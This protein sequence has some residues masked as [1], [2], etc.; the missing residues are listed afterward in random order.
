MNGSTDWLSAAAIVS[1][2]IIVGL[3]L[4]Y[5]A[6]RKRGTLRAETAFRDL[7]ARRDELVDE[8]RQGDLSVEARTS[9]EI[10]TANVLREIDQ[11]SKA[12]HPAEAELPAPNPFRRGLL[13]G[14]AS[15]AGTVLILA[16][17]GIFVIESAKTSEGMGQPRAMGSPDA[18]AAP[19]AP[20][21]S[22][23]QA[24]QRLEA[25]VAKSPDDLDARVALARAYLD[26]NNLMGVFDQTKYVLAKSPDDSRALT[27]HAVVRVAMG[28]RDEASA[29]L[30]RATKADPS[31]LDAWIA[32]AWM[33]VQQG[34]LPKAEA[35][36]NEAAKRHPEEKGRLD[37]ML[38]NMKMQTRQQDAAGAKPLPEGHPAIGSEGVNARK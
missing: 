29:M 19:A 22:S 6:R 2:G 15:G 27:Y 37:L 8:L 18:P 3:L 25:A 5:F 12:S 21:S 36:M 10:E 11:R 20:A 17:L 7:E 24:V 16:G 28:Q 26:R 38:D 1:A 9:L 35:A 31:F 23:D 33:N 14:F 30:A 34:D 13:V 32:I 4:I